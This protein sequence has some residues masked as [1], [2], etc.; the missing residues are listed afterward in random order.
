VTRVRVT[1]GHPR[2][3]DGS[4]VVAGAYVLR[5]LRDLGLTKRKVRDAAAV[6][7]ELGAAYALATKKIV[8]DGID[9]FLD[10]ADGDLARVGDPNRGS[11]TTGAMSG[12]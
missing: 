7:G 4:V 2:P 10:Y 12:Y 11:M 3:A 1:V 5:S 9:I 8:T 6:R